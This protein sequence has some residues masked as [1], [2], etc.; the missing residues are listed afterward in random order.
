MAIVIKEE[1]NKLYEEDVTPHWVEGVIETS[2]GRVRRIK[3][4]LD[5][6]DIIDGCKV[7]W[8]INR[9]DYQIS[10]GLYAVGNPDRKSPV[11][12]T[13]NYKLTFDKLRKELSNQNLWIMVID[14]KGIN[15]WCAAGKG[16]FGTK[17]IVN[18]IKK[19]DLKKVVDHNTIILPQ[20]GA[21]GVA[22]HIITRAT[23]FKVVFGPIRAVDIPEFLS[24][25]FT[26]SS[27]MRQVKFGFIDRLVLTP[28]EIVI[29]LKY[30]PLIFIVFFILNL[31]NPMGIN[32]AVA[33]KTAVFN[34][35]PYVG[36]LFIGAVMLPVLL[37]YI[38]FRTFV[39]KGIVLGV[40]WS[41][42]S[43]A[44]NNFFAFSNSVLLYM[45]NGLLLTTIIAFISLNFTGSTTYTSLSGVALETKKT[46]P[47]AMGTSVLGI[48]LI[49]AE[50]VLTFL[51]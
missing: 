23:G 12:V 2:V 16:T 32:L 27:E 10:P 42:I 44:L 21:P 7:R 51:G 19:I 22:A 24:K 36:A 48:I 9:Y 41:V 38:P 47:V 11:L 20:L 13:A 34:S 3:T 8:G 43:I 18:R 25:G 17:E 15:V 4:K 46:I 33:F 6:K 31:I 29:N 26:A 14:T 1:T 30:V 39:L 28:M 40:I 50:K 37:P 45:A 5:K 35:L 49:I